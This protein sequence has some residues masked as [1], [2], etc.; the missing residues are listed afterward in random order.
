MQEISQGSSGFQ[1]SFWE[2]NRNLAAGIILASAV[3]AGTI[4]YMLRRSRE[5]EPT[6]ASIAGRAWGR[7][8]ETAGEERV[9]AA[10]EFVMDKVMPE[11]KP[12]LLA[13]LGELEDAVDEYFRRAEK[14]IKRM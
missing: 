4:A 5:E 9:D 11:L 1:G 7:A 2:E 10:R 13:I 3:A 8:R 14:A 12:A 6:P